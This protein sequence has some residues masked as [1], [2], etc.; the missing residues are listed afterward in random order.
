MTLRFKTNLLEHAKAVG[1]WA[2]RRGAHTSIDAAD[3]ALTLQFE[4]RTHT[5][6][7]QFVGK[8]DGLQLCY[9]DMPDQ[10]ATGFVGWLPYK[11]QA[12]DISLSKLAFKAAARDLDIPTPAHW[13]QAS[14]V[15]APFLVKRERG[16]FGY[17]MQ[18]PFRASEAAQLALAEGEYCEEFKWGH[19]ARAWY[20][21]ERLSVLELFPMPSV[22]GDGE[23]SYESLLLRASAELPADFA[24]LGRLQG[25]EP[26]AV[27]AAGQRIVCDYR[28]V[29]PF[30]PTLYANHNV[31]PRLRGSA[32]TQQFA[33]AGARL[34]PRIPGPPGRQIGFVLDAIVDAQGQPWFLEVNSNPQWHPDIYASMLDGLC[35]LAVR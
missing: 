33:A 29:S 15:S 18:G 24:H 27:P 20:W 32:L 30:N 9:F 14:S 34:W 11:P 7:A 3:L 31:L 17:G 2:Q 26:S 35:G 8:R 10:F 6:F 12:W 19:I 25:V 13:T 4:Q 5:L 1:A 21:G 16:A 22:T 28:Y 23:S